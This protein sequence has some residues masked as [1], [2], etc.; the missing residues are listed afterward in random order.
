LLAERILLRENV[1]SGVSST[2]R[3][4]PGALGLP[5]GFD[6]HRRGSFASRLPTAI[7]RHVDHYAN[8][9]PPT[10]VA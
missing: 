8:W 7:T 2:A 9:A 10:C 5:D 4:Q 6:L 3:R 1:T